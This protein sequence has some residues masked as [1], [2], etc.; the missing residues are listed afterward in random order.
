MVPTWKYILVTWP[1]YMVLGFI[2]PGYMVLG[3]SLGYI[4]TGVSF[5]TWYKGSLGYMV[6]GGVIHLTT[7]HWGYY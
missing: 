2:S 6:L 7:W 3:G 4:M 5:T 1:G